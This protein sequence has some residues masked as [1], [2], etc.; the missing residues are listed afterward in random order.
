[1]CDDDAKKGKEG[2]CVVCFKETELRKATC[3][4]CKEEGK[5]IV[6]WDT[7]FKRDLEDG[8]KR[9]ICFMHAKEGKKG[10]WMVPVK[11]NGTKRVLASH[12][13]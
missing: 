3:E 2:K 7:S 6:D 12:Q 4:L 13:C 10:K 5:E 9:V 8:F 11:G 1:M